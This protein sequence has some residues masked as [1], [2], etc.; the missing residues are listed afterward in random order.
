MTDANTMT[1][2]IAD[3]ASAEAEVPVAPQPWDDVLPESFQMLRLAPQPTDRAT[4]GR[5]LRFVQFGLGARQ[6]Q[7]AGLLR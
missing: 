3:P 4:G 6:R 1:E 2:T 5:P 7:G